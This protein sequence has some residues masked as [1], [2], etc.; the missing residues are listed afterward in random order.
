MEH[1]AI[2]PFYVACAIIGLVAWFTKLEAK[3][4]RNADEIKEAKKAIEDMR[5]KHT[6]LE[7]KLVADIGE[8]KQALARIEGQLS[9]K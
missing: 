4:N 9:A 7:A 6:D 8:V 5:E 2:D 3:G 1:I